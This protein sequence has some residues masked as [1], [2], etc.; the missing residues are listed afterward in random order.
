MGAALGDLAADLS[1]A[2]P[3]DPF[4]FNPVAWL[5]QTPREAQAMCWFDLCAACG[6]RGLN[7]E[8]DD[9]N[10]P[11]GGYQQHDDYGNGSSSSSNGSSKK[12]ST[13]SLKDPLRLEDGQLLFCAD[14]GEGFHPFCLP[15]S[16]P[17]ATMDPVTRLGWR[18]VFPFFSFAFCSFPGYLLVS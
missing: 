2:P 17:L 18:C 15:M 12:S 10:E 4:E 11:Q 1:L 14:C 6:A 9:E 3:K 7:E 5:L 16:L 8:E 13:G